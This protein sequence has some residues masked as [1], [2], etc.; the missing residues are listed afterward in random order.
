MCVQRVACAN[1]GVWQ[2]ETATPEI[3]IAASEIEERYQLSFWDALAVA[4]ASLGHAE[5]LLTEDLNS[6]Q[7]IE[8][9][10]IG[11]ALSHTPTIGAS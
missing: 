3:I 7:T 4:A 6:G 1:Y 5:L 10:R 11:C 9:V 8:G 2:V